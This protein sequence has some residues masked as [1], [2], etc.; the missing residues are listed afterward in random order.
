METSHF[1]ENDKKMFRRALELVRVA[2][3]KGLNDVQREEFLLIP[4][5]IRKNAIDEVNL[6]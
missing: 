4:F 1:N 5:S 2:N 6:K 3:K